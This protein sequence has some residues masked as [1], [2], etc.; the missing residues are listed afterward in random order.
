L[1]WD[2]SS[3]PVGSYSATIRVTDANQNEDRQTITVLLGE[4]PVFTLQPDAQGWMVDVL[5]GGDTVLSAEAR[6]TPA[7]TY[8]WYYYSTPIPGATS[9]T[10]TLEDVDYGDAGFY[11][12]RATNIFGAPLSEDIYVNVQE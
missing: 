3:L 4:K 2:Y 12:V 9:A 6:G 5:I 11:Q 1:T 8:Q 10:L 7:P